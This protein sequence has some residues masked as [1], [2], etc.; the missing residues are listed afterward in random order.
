MD[1]ADA[2]VVYEDADWC[3]VEASAES[4]VVEFSAV[5][6]GDCSVAVDDVVSDSPVAADGAVGSDFGG[7]V[8]TLVGCFPSEGS[9]WSLTVVVV[10]EGVDLG[11]ELLEGVDGGLFGEPFFEGLLEAFNFPLALGMVG[12]TVFLGDG[13]LA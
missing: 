10:A 5:T 7:C 1:D 13:E 2:A 4:D 9:V 6:Q 8:V 11:L 12:S 3:A